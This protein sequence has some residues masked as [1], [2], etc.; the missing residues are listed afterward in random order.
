VAAALRS[1]DP[2]ALAGKNA[3][4]GVRV[5]PHSCAVPIGG[6]ESLRI[7]V[8]G[9]LDPRFSAGLEELVLDGAR[10]TR[11]PGPA[12][13]VVTVLAGAGLGIGV[14]AP[15]CERATAAARTVIKASADPD[16]VALP[17]P[18]PDSCDLLTRVAGER[19]AELS[20]RYGITEM[21]QC[22]AVRLL[23]GKDGSDGDGWTTRYSVRIA[24]G[25]L[26]GVTNEKPGT[27]DGRAVTIYDSGEDCEYSWKVGAAPV[28]DPNLSER[29]L[30][31][32]APSCGEA[33]ELAVG[34]MA[35]ETAL[36]EPVTPQRPIT[37]PA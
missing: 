30:R 34:V 7:D 18:Q 25:R 4:G 28:D 17:D 35:I 8:G 31:V 20:V 6:E 12:D 26:A 14:N 29:L 23:S 3:S 37:V 15:S 22:Q 13:C 1:L 27:L 16:R 33:A 2:C 5:G 36:P 10:V 32:R 21:G 24:H 19:L 11:S 9:Y